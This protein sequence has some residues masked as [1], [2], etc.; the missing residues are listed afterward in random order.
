MSHLSLHSTELHL[1]CCVPSLRSMRKELISKNRQENLSL[2]SNFL[3]SNV[4]VHV[5]SASFFPDIW[6]DLF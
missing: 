3:F 5:P 1:V 4:V 2:F 6:S